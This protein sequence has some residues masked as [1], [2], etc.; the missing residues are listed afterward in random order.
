MSKANEL[1]P[2]PDKPVITINLPLGIFISIFFKLCSFA[3]RMTMSLISNGFP[4]FDIYILLILT[5]YK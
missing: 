5:K 2:D 3:P 1:F 4:A